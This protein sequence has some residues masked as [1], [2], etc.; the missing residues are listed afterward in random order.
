MTMTMTDTQVLTDR[1]EG[2]LTLTMNQPTR[3]NAL[4][5]AMLSQLNEAVRTA[6]RDSS[7]RAVVL[8]GAG[9]AFSSGADLTEFDVSGDTRPDVREHLTRTLNPLASRLHAMEKPVLAAVNGIAAGAGLSLALACD[10]RFAAESARLSVAFVKIGLVPDTGLF[11][12]L[13]RLI[14]PAKTL[15]LA[16]TGDAISAQ[17]ALTLGMLNRVTP[18]A[19]VLSETQALAARL[20]NGPATAIGLIKRAVSQAHEL[21][22][23]RLLELE[24][25]Y[26]TIASRTADFAEGVTAF[27][28]KRAP[29]FS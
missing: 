11:Y 23:D 20:S 13:P 14:G 1:H 28:E 24:A 26:Q 21:P 5:S 25:G 3:Y 17:E 12:F 8:T 7:V 9:A 2:V 29:R 18:D 27:R 19:S 22:L 4:S 16:W 10:V 15:E 6:E